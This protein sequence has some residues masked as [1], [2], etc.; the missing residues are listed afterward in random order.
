[1]YTAAPLAFLI[2]HAHGVATDGQ[3]NTLDQPIT[4]ASELTSFY[5]GGSNDVLELS[6]YLNASNPSYNVAV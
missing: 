2:H 5:C 4:S 6:Q 3:V 1:M